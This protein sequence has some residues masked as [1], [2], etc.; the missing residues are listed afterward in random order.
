MRQL[1]FALPFALLPA[2]AFADD[3]HHHHIEHASLGSHQH[4]VAQ[5]DVAL[6]GTVL[7]IELRSPAINLLGFEHAPRSAADKD[8]LADARARLEQPN[9]LFGLPPRARCVLEEAHL[10]SP[11]L[12]D[13]AQDHGQHDGSTHSDLHVRYRYDCRAPEAL[14]GLDLQALFEAFPRTEKI[15]AQVIGP[16][17]QQGKQLHATQTRITF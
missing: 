11:L 4:G 7:E 9:N 10:E 14:P 17:G 16:N 15:R 8:K 6:D 3:D 12:D 5:L 1:L 13:Q 2:I